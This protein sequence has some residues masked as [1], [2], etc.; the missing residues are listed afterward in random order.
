MFFSFPAL[1]SFT[2][3]CNVLFYYKLTEM[4]SFKYSV[5]VNLL[6][7]IIVK[8]YILMYRYESCPLLMAYNLGEKRWTFVWKY[9]SNIYKICFEQKKVNIQEEVS[10]PGPDEQKCKHVSIELSRHT[11]MAESY[12]SIR[13][14]QLISTH[15]TGDLRNYYHPSFLPWDA[16]WWCS[17]FL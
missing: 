17:Y 5:F 8:I 12:K 6:A 4:E 7:V 15:S 2:C 11:V 14:D 10:K 3:L 13:N 16:R 1:F 9:Q